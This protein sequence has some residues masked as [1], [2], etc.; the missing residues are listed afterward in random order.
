MNY[1]ATEF[2]DVRDGLSR[3]QRVI[4]HCLHI[5]E[6]EKPGCNISTCML[7]GRVF[8]HIDIGVDEMQAI[9]NTITAAG[10][11]DDKHI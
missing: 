9:L 3:K 1:D 5:L 11:L 2:S 7:Y 4:I 10:D 8:E 6:A